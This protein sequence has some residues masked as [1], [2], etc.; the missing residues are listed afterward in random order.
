[1]IPKTNFVIF[2]VVV[3]VVL[4]IWF[5]SLEKEVNGLAFE[6]SCY[7]EKPCVRFCCKDEKLCDQKYIN[8]NFNASLLP[9]DEYTGWNGTQGLTAHF[10]KPNCT[11]SS[12]DSKNAFEF[13]L[14]IF[15]FSTNLVLT[16]KFNL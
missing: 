5:Y 11:L 1:M 13:Q 14:V 9:E 3:Y 4:V 2:A 16:F 7:F 10:G 6:R 8:D 15:Y 12:I